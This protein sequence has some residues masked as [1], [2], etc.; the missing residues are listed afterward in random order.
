MLNRS[1]DDRN[2]CL[3]GA[4]ITRAITADL[5]LGLELFHQS[6]DALDSKA[7]TMLGGGLTYDISEHYHFLAYWGPGLQ[8]ARETGRSDWYTALLFTF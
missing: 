6:A 5:R 1:G 8:N 7:S 3:G 4:A 2:F